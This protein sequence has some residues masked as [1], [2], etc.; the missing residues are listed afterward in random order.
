MDS[1]SMLGYII[2]S[3]QSEKKW[4]RIQD[5]MVSSSRLRAS[6]QDLGTL[7]FNIRGIIR[8]HWMSVFDV[9]VEY[10]SKGKFERW[11]HVSSYS[12][13]FSFHP[14]FFLHNL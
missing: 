5:A 10:G 9:F 3:L 1:A 8:V 14:S 7:L 11:N 2:L 13:R 6:I 12:I 4:I